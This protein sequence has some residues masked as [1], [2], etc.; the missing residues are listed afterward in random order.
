MIPA[1]TPLTRGLTRAYHP[2]HHNQVTRTLS[3]QARWIMVPASI[4]SQRRRQVRN[5]PS[6]SCT[7]RYL[8]LTRC[9][10]ALTSMITNPIWVIKVR[11]CAQEYGTGYRSFRGTSPFRLRLSSSLWLTLHSFKTRF[12]KFTQTKVLAAFT[13]GSSPPCLASCTAASSSWSTRNSSTAKHW[14]C[15]RLWYCFSLGLLHASV[16]ANFTPSTFRQSTISQTPLY[17]RHA[18]QCAR[19]LTK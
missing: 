19:T 17:P 2:I 16:N 15:R 13:E 6:R 5:L 14:R 11:M 7:C 12:G 9:T 1:Q 8:C 3:E 10:G 4:C 18:R